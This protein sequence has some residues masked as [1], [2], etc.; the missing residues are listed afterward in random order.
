MFAG[1]EALKVINTITGPLT[2]LVNIAADGA[3]KLLA[4][5]GAEDA[6]GASASGATGGVNGLFGA[7]SRLASLSLPGWLAAVLG[8]SATVGAAALTFGPALLT[9]GDQARPTNSRQDVNY[10]NWLNAHPISG[11]T[12]KGD[13]LQAVN[14]SYYLQTGSYPSFT[15]TA[16]SQL[17]NI[18]ASFG[19]PAEQALYTK[20]FG[21]LP[22]P[23]NSINP[24]DVNGLPDPF[25]SINPQTVNSGFIP[26]AP[27]PGGGQ[28]TPSHPLP[29]TPSAG[30]VNAAAALLQ[31]A[32]VNLGAA[33]YQGVATGINPL[34]PLF[35]TLTSNLKG[36]AQTIA[37]DLSNLF[38]TAVSAGQA[39]TQSLGIN[40]AT[41]Q[42]LPQ[43]GTQTNVTFDANGVRHDQVVSPILAQLQG[44]L[45]TDKT[46]ISD[47]A[48]LTKAGFG[49]GIVQQFEAAGPTSDAAIQSLLSGSSG[50]VTSIN[51]AFGAVNSQAAAYGQAIAQ[52]QYLSKIVDL[53]TQLLAA[54]KAQDSHPAATG[55]A[56][57][58]SI[59]GAAKTALHKIAT[60]PNKGPF[61]RAQ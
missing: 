26:S 56:V 2:T 4:F 25:N 60:T 15:G 10:Q 30:T 42:G 59:N 45:S 57:G 38:S 35:S 8:G 47:L 36:S 44:A 52:T 48:K 19:N 18:T 20:L 55:A 43:F 14:D 28:G 7:V 6:V 13:L 16:L 46:Y 34:T 40:V 23:F 51:A 37:I 31:L 3:V 53:E 12:S 61:S 21:A 58:A 41:G 49:A 17:G 29:L 22:V 9:S 33:L 32:G 5:A 1:F 24:Q 11:I 27:P 39:A 54:T 50:S